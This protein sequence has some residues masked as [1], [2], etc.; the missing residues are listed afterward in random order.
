VA[1]AYEEGNKPLF[2]ILCWKFLCPLRYYP[3]LKNTYIWSQYIH[4]GLLYQ[5]LSN[6]EI[7]QGLKQAKDSLLNGYMQCSKWAGICRYNTSE[8]LFVP[9]FHTATYQYK[10]HPFIFFHFP[11][12][13]PC[14]AFKNYTGTS[15]L[16]FLTLDRCT[17]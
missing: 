12:A 16:P 11:L 14:F 17:L 9:E 3:L 8:I 10:L 5:I 7:L 4:N 13:Y 1:G 15:K 2:F 6:P